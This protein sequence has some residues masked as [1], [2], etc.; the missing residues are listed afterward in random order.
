M[1]NVTLL[2][3]FF[4]FELSLDAQ[5]NVFVLVDVSGSGPADAIKT[6]AGVIVKDLLVDQ[7]NP[8]NYNKEW[9]WS[10]SLMPPFDRVKG[11]SQPLLNTAAGSTLM[12]MPFGQHN[13]YED[14]KIQKISNLPD[15]VLSMFASYYPKTFSD[16]YTYIEVAQAKAAGVAKTAGFDSFY[17]IEVTDAMPIAPQSK[18][19]PQEQFLMQNDNST[20]TK[21]GEFVFGQTDFRIIFTR[22]SIANAPN[23][24]KTPIATQNIDRKD[25]TIIKPSGTQKK[26]TTLNPPSVSIAWRCLGCKDSTLYNVTLLNTKDKK[27]RIAPKKTMESSATFSITEPGEYKVSVSGDGLT[28][29][30]V[31]FKVGKEGGGSGFWV[32]LLL[33]GAGFLGYFFWNKRRNENMQR[34][35]NDLAGGYTG[36][37]PPAQ[38]NAP[39]QKWDDPDGF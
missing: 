30:S 25:L 38:S 22:V 27:V 39:K 26:P 4:L 7:F 21:L 33:I 6:E 13:R 23:L 10:D 8:S 24:V 31:Y 5:N 1:R 28:A 29:K 17:R 36:Y 34:V 11:T 12:I 35:P 20:K 19:T 18:Y 16:Q 37:Q 15:D 3:L 14:Y 9:K 2:F 32:V